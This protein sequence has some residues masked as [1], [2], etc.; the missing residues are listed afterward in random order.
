MKRLISFC[1]VAVAACAIGCGGAGIDG[2]A[3]RVYDS[4][5]PLVMEAKQG[6]TQISA[7]E[8]RQKIDNEEMFVLI[9]VREPYEFDENMIDGA[10]NVP[11]GVLEFKIDNEAFWDEQGMYVPE[12]TE[13]LILYCKKGDRGA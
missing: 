9:D 10:F 7:D 12:K 4:V 5:K 3:P 6:I 2:R 8:L 11:R 13:E 1:L